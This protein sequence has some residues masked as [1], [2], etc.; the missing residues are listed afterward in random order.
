M[1]D[2]MDK[3]LK[4]DSIEFVARRFNHLEHREII[5]DGTHVRVIP[6]FE[7]LEIGP[8]DL[9]EI[10]CMKKGEEETE[11]L[12]AWSGL[13]TLPNTKEHFRKLA[14]LLG[15]RIDV[16]RYSGGSGETWPQFSVAPCENRNPW[17]VKWEE[18]LREVEISYNHVGPT[19]KGSPHRRWI[20]W[21]SEYLTPS[22][23]ELVK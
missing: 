19:R 6:F 10:F 11:S 5:V 21:L 20:H 12:L 16:W 2:W 23:K 13:G 8:T 14:N 9:Q 4:A 17:K 1:N 7:A 3:Y 22:V 18:F 15:K